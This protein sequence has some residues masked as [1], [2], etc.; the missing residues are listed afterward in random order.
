VEVPTNC[1][2]TGNADDVGATEV[3]TTPCAPGA[4]ES[5]SGARAKLTLRGIVTSGGVDA[6]DAIKTLAAMDACEETTG[7]A[8]EMADATAAVG[9]GGDTTGVV[10]DRELSQKAT[11]RGADTDRPRATAALS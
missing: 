1:D 6:D 4:I 3:T 5:P 11:V 8:E 7:K 10:T 2:S 9:T